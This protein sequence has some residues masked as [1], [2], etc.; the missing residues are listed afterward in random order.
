[1]ET[2]WA[3]RLHKHCVVEDSGELCVQLREAACRYIELQIA[4]RSRKSS[5]SSMSAIYRSSMSADELAVDRLIQLAEERAGARREISVIPREMETSR[6][7]F[8]PVPRR[9][10]SIAPWDDP[11]EEP[12]Q[13]DREDDSATD[14]Q[15]DDGGMEDGSRDSGDLE[16]GQD[17]DDPGDSGPEDP[18]FVRPRRPLRR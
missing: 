13:G 15:S 7:S 2:V 10:S 1:M 16:Q 11:S 3:L 4:L 9:G 5:D 17:G 12:G 8:A 14:E 6:S 18:S